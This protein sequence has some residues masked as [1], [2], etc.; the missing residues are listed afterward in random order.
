MVICDGRPCPPD[1]FDLDRDITVYPPDTQFLDLFTGEHPP[2]LQEPPSPGDPEML[3]RGFGV[4]CEGRPSIPGAPSAKGGRD[5]MK[6][7]CGTGNVS[8][9]RYSSSDA[10]YFSCAP[11][12]KVGNSL[13]QT[14][15]HTCQSHGDKAQLPLLTSHSNSV[16]C[17]CASWSSHVTIF[18][19]RSKLGIRFLC[20]VF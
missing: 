2:F 18:L 16:H 9:D 1:A 6:A 7:E 15:K 13:E 14:D 20:V 5:E 17:F 11:V 12:W 8:S 3:A 4:G 10:S 19:R